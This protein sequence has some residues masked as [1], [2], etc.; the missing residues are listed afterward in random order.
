MCIPR[1]QNCL[2]KCESMGLMQYVITVHVCASEQLFV[3][4]FYV[5]CSIMYKLFMV[6]ASHSLILASYKK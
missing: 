2:L 5:Q 3:Y 4:L 1:S 6:I